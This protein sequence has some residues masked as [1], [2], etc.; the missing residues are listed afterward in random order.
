MHAGR[1]AGPTARKKPRDPGHGSKDK[2]TGLNQE[3]P[4]LEITGL[5]S[6]NGRGLLRARQH[7]DNNRE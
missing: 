4:V 3:R 5:D 2:D 7:I 1:M 6:G